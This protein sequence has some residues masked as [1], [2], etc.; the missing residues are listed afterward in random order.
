MKK[1]EE[2]DKQ[3]VLEG[4]MKEVQT[5]L[6]EVKESYEQCQVKC[7]EVV[8]ENLQLKEEYEIIKKN[9]SEVNEQ[10]TD[11]VWNN[12]G[13]NV[14]LIQKLQTTVDFS[15]EKSSCLPVVSATVDASAFSL[16]SFLEF[17]ETVL[18]RYIELLCLYNV[19]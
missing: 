12:R 17:I 15:N 14:Q 11:S 16:K 3:N 1:K 10:L 9:S 7:D 5:E 2:N 18:S 6:K 8:K 13:S 19:Q 4:A